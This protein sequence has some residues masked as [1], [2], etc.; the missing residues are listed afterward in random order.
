[1]NGYEEVLRALGRIE[2]ELVEIRKLSARVR[3]IEAGVLIGY[4]CLCRL[5][6]GYGPFNQ[7]A[8]K[9]TRWQ[10][11]HDVAESDLCVIEGKI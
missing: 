6:F 1:M 2:G 3:A 8:V 5:A 9:G 10:S 4:L 11:A 7:I